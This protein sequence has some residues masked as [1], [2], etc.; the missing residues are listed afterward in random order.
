MKTINKLQSVKP[1]IKAKAAKAKSDKELTNKVFGNKGTKRNTN[2]TTKV[3]DADKR[4]CKTC[5]KLHMGECWLLK[6]GGNAGNN[7]LTWRNGV[8]L[9]LMLT[10]VL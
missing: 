8:M 7:N 5:K 9:M 1:E 4:P 2:G 3:S 10:K 6:N